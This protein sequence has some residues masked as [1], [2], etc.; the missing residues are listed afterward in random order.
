MNICKN[1]PSCSLCLYMFWKR[2][3]SVLQPQQLI[4][5]RCLYVPSGK[6]I[7]LGFQSPGGWLRITSPL[8]RENPIEQALF[9]EYIYIL[10]QHETPNRF[11]ASHCENLTVIIAR[12]NPLFGTCHSFIHSSIGTLAAPPGL[13]GGTP[14]SK[15]AFYLIPKAKIGIHE[16][17]HEFET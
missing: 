12:W 11:L 1:W 5:R 2:P 14:K 3:T 16:M 9:G 4:F 6:H 15:L 8:F 17:N 7:L 10:S 13:P